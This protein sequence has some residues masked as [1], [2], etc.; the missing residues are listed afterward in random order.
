[1]IYQLLTGICA[2]IISGMGIGGGLILIPILTL[3]FGFDQKIA[4]GINIFYFI[5]TSIAALLV[6]FKNKTVDKKA[7]FVLVLFGICGAVLGGILAFAI[8]S[9]HLRDIFGLFLISMGVYIFSKNST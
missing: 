4:Q 6:H 3:V 2:G 8:S 5:P 7:A 9:E 1:M